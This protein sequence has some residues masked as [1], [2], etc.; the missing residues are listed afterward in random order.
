MTLVR[1]IGSSEDFS[2]RLTI[3]FPSPKPRLDKLKKRLPELQ[4]EVSRKC[5]TAT[6]QIRYV[7]RNPINATVPAIAVG[8]VITYR[9]VD[10]ASKKFGERLGDDLYK[11]AKQFLKTLNRR[12]KSK[13]RPKR[14]R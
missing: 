13:P 7:Q 3:S 14:H 12:V 11:T 9:I 10:S 1:L 8:L 5:P 2:E 4:R 6:V